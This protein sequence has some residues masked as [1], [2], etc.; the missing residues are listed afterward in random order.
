MR[1]V[2]VDELAQHLRAGVLESI[3]G[4]GI[5]DLHHVCASTASGSVLTKLENAAGAA[6][7]K[8]THGV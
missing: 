6:R 1:Q 4:L 2:E 5:E 8:L 7:T 3:D